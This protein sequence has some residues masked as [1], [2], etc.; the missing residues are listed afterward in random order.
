MQAGKNLPGTRALDEHKMFKVIDRN[1]GQ[2]VLTDE[3]DAKE[4]SFGLMLHQKET[5]ASI[6]KFTGN[7]L[8]Y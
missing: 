8:K 4:L 2:Y 5:E 3:Q 7:M 6:M 1:F